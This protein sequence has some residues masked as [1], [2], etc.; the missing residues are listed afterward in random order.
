MNKFRI[1]QSILLLVSVI[2]LVISVPAYA[3]N[4]GISTASA[5]FDIDLTVCKKT[6]DWEIFLQDLNNNVP[7]SNPYS[8]SVCGPENTLRITDIKSNGFIN[9][10]QAQVGTAQAKAFFG[11]DP[12]LDIFQNQGRPAQSIGVNSPAPVDRSVASSLPSIFTTEQL[13]QIYSTGGARTGMPRLFFTG[14][15]DANNDGIN[16]RD[17]YNPLRKFIS[18]ASGRQVN[19]GTCATQ[20]P[21]GTFIFD[22]NKCN[23]VD[24]TNVSE[25]LINGVFSPNLCEATYIGGICEAVNGQIRVRE[26]RAGFPYNYTADSNPATPQTSCARIVNGQRLPAVEER[27][28]QV[29]Q[30]LYE[31]RYPTAAQ[32][33]RIPPAGVDFNSCIEFYQARYGRDLAGNNDL[34]SGSRT[35]STYTFYGSFDDKNSRWVGW[36]NPNVDIDTRNNSNDS[37]VRGYRGFSVYEF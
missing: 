22:T 19:Y 28:L 25:C 4:P 20:Q 8:P 15:Q 23:K 3:A 10:N 30:F 7:N 13:N 33:A 36:R 2:T 12:I 24:T 31:F 17:V 37:L 27:N 26:R 16:D 32:C 18:R 6:F 1:I 34:N 35:L 21:N 29:Y 14:Y 11:N 5:K 9:Y